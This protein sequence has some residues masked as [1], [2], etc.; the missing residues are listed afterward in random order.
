[1]APEQLGG[2]QV[3]AR[4][5]LYALGIVLH[6]LYT[7]RR[8][9]DGGATLDVDPDVDRVIRWCTAK[10]PADRPANARAVIAALPGGD[11]LAAALAAGE[12]PSPDIVAAAG[13]HAGLHP[14]HAALLALVFF[15]GLL[16]YGWVGNGT[17]LFRYVPFDLTPDVL[18][19]KAREHLDSLGIP[20]PA[21][22]VWGFRVDAS[23]LAWLKKKDGAGGRAALATGRPAAVQF[24]YRGSPNAL[25]PYGP[26]P[27]EEADPPF[28]RPGE[29]HLRLDT[30]GRL[31]ELLAQPGTGWPA[32]PAREGWARLF[33]AAGLDLA[34]FHE[35]APEAAPPVPADARAAWTGTMGDAPAVPLRVEAALWQGTPVFFEVGGPWR[36]AGAAEAVRESRRFSATVVFLLLLLPVGMSAWLA[37]R[38][39]TR[40]RSDPRAAVR[41]G[42]VVQLVTFALA[43]ANLRLSQFTSP[44]LSLWIVDTIGL[45]CFLGLAVSV[46]YLALEPEIRRLRPTWLITW[47][48]AVGGEVRDPLVGTHVLLGLALG[49]WTACVMNLTA[50]WWARAGIPERVGAV[51]GLSGMLSPMAPL[52]PALARAMLYG[53]V[54]TFLIVMI[55]RWVR[56]ARLPEAIVI[57]S[58]AAVEFLSGPPG[59]YRLP[60][61]VFVFTLGF[62]MFRNVGLLGLVTWLFTHELIT[63]YPLTLDLWAWYP[64]RLWLTVT[65]V[66]GPLAV[67]A[68]RTATSSGVPA[69]GP[70]SRQSRPATARRA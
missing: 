49:A 14:R 1:M 62:V 16:I 42:I 40:E 37:W 29:M 45:S 4:S 17:V 69:V 33:S 68:C 3:T 55:R 39:W 53:L 63:S 27:V 65:L 34:R 12:T 41:L 50:L 13:T 38:N 56:V 64:P 31:C 52:V 61:T 9:G 23:Y 19:Q 15:G 11:P 28:D 18:A 2:R 32:A 20:R 59:S 66:L 54:A 8:P 24:A 43:C 6:E 58:F 25:L 36:E 21:A 5:D 48:R 51:R 57:A 47:T 22:E 60:A 30:R 67:W 70:Q 46:V 44:R 26:G 35:S 7:G 10:D